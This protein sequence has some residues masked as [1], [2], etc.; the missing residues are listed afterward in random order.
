MSQEK[1]EKPQ[2]RALSVIG[3]IAFFVGMILAVAGGIFAQGNGSIILILVILGIIV[4]FLNITSK[5]VV[6]FLVA[7]IALV[8]VGN[9]GFAS[10]DTII[11]GLG[12]A[13][14]GI[15]GYIGTFMIPAAII[16]AVKV[17]WQLAKP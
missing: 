1:A 2:G 17:V 3:A 10:L 4:G 12:K 8:V 6:P 7:A 5:E 13:L 14:D 15:V 11:L 16:N 9:G